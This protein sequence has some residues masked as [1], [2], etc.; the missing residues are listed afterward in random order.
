MSGLFTARFQG[1]GLSVL[2]G[3]LTGLFYGSGSTTDGLAV[4]AGQTRP[5]HRLLSWEVVYSTDQMDHFC[6]TL[7]NPDLTLLDHPALQPNAHWRV[8]FGSEGQLCQPID[9]VVTHRQGWF[10]LTIGGEMQAERKLTQTQQQQKWTHKRLS[11][12]A[13]ELLTQAGLIPVVDDTKQLLPVIVR[14]H[15]TAWQ[16]LQRKAKET[17]LA[18][19]V[20]AHGNKGYF[21]K[22]GTDKTPHHVLQML[23]G[24]VGSTPVVGGRDLP[25]PSF[26][27]GQPTPLQLLEEPQLC[28]EHTNVATQETLCGFDPLTKKSF[29]VNANSRTSRQ[30]LLAP[31]PALC[32]TTSSLGR[33]PLKGNP[34]VG[35][36]FGGGGFG[37]SSTTG[38]ARPTSL[39]TQK[40]AQEAV[41][42]CFAAKQLQGCRL[43][44]TVVGTPSLVAGD[45]VMLHCPA[46]SMAGRWLLQE[47]KHSCQEGS[48]TCELTLHRNASEPPQHAKRGTAASTT[49]ARVNRKRPQ[50]KPAERLYRFGGDEGKLYKETQSQADARVQTQQA[51]PASPS[52]KPPTSPQRASATGPDYIHD[53]T[54]GTLKKQ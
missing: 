30:T 8:R 38:C 40:R 12:V 29:C 54:T 4:V 19:T 27:V 13:R 6:V 32:P 47:V 18:Y 16:F 44:C 39:P 37:A 10:Q 17:G 34:L 28:E 52:T 49:R 45:V 21:V 35:N 36:P 26:A 20:Y 51:T 33:N 5:T 2:G 22:Q 43:T 25:L 9:C 42:S 41:N 24:A 31:Q 7:A 11:D 53:P 50:R 3:D 14:G 48:Y 46:N 23:G 15:E 1:S